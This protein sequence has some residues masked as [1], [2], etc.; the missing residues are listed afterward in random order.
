MINHIAFKKF[1][2]SQNLSTRRFGDQC[3]L[4]KSTVHRLGQPDHG[5][6]TPGYVRRIT[7]QV[8]EACRL[9]L[10]QTGTIADAVHQILTN[11][12]GDDF[13]PMTIYK[14]ALTPEML[15]FFRLPRDPFAAPR[16]ASDLFT[17][18]A[19]DEIS[20]Q[21]EEAV[22]CQ[23]FVC[24][25]A[26]VGAGKTMM[27]NKLLSA[28]LFSPKSNVQS[29]TSEE[30]NV[31]TGAQASPLAMDAQRTQ[32]L[33]FG[34]TGAQASPLAMDA[35]RTQTLDFGPTGAQAS[36]LAMDAQRTQTLDFG[37]TGAQASPLAMDAQRTQTL[38]LGPGTLDP[39]RTLDLGPGTLDR[40]ILSPAFADM[41]R[42]TAAGI[43]AYVLEELG[44]KPRRSL[45]LAQKQL[46]KRLADLYRQNIRIALCFD[47]C[48]R[49]SDTTLTALKN[50]YELGSGG[51]ER[52]LGLLLFGQPHFTARLALPRFRE[53]AERLAVIDPLP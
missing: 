34:P 2:T 47:E 21:L 36:P 35:Q 48:H 46:E 42:V 5:G 8:M 51:F 22:R 40:I 19:L 49:V 24:V 6:L 37:P 12:F 3:G 18:P 4:S 14:H 1:L 15:R 52:Y 43:V 32:T 13:T 50:F 30:S 26:P 9:H 20:R 41:S 44:E 27:K 28:A 39:D 16:S 29:P 38:D 17:T 7:P 25:L 33:D 10:E 31:T 45:V 23:G 11:I 53:I